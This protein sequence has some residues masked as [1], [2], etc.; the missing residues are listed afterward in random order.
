MP[1]TRKIS[2]HANLTSVLSWREAGSIGAQPDLAK[3]S[4]RQHMAPLNSTL[5]GHKD[6]SPPIALGS[7]CVEAF[8]KTNPEP[9]WL[10]PKWL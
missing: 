10:E 3:G 5:L 8:W 9:K 1:A 4:S 2:E 7:A 6:T